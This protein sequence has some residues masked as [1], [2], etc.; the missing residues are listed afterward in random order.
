M[1]CPSLPYIQ[2]LAFHWPVLLISSGASLP[3]GCFEVLSQCNELPSWA[4]WGGEPL[5]SSQYRSRRGQRSMP[6]Y[7]IVFPVLPVLTNNRAVHMSLLF[8]LWSIITVLGAEYRNWGMFHNY[9]ISINY[10]NLPWTHLMLQLLPDAIWPIF[11]FG[12][13]VMKLN[14]R[15]SYLHLWSIFS[16]RLINWNG[17]KKKNM[18]QQPSTVLI[19]TWRSGWS[20]ASRG[21]AWL[22]H[23]H[24]ICCSKGSGIVLLGGVYFMFLLLRHTGAGFTVSH[25][26]L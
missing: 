22:K 11:L 12:G 21:R 10:M 16:E 26:G 17:D 19:S 18:L 20:V 24:V 25:I 13:C 15:T 4:L 3:I 5:P 6:G 8:L 23:L 7:S 9:V 14:V 2:Q 1:L